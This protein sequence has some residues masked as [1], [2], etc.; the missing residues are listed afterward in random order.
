MR[1]STLLSAAALLVVSGSSLGQALY[2]N[3]GGYGSSA[4]GLSTGAT[5]GSGVAAPAGSLWS[6]AQA[7]AG[8]ANTSA[9]FSAFTSTGGNFRLADDF[10]V[11]AGGSWN[12]TNILTYGYQTG[13]AAGT[14]PITGGTIN[15]WN[16]A[17]NVVGSSIVASGTYGGSTNTN[18]FRVFSTTTPA[19]GSAPGTTRLIRQASWNFSSVTL[20][21]G[22]YWVD[23]QYTVSAAAGTLFVPAIT[24]PGT[25]TLPGWN[26]IQANA[27]VW[28]P[29]IDTGNPATGPDVAQDFPFVIIPAPSAAALLGLGGLCAAR[30]RRA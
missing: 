11:P 6:E 23:F 16:G 29:A 7:T 24:I 21:P 20:N 22:T 14:Q 19:P 18:L 13:S 3:A 8:T 30:R 12:V 27:G 1:H 4:I 26:A 2:S 15:I 28:A 17:P 5:T 10:T 9:G 25:R